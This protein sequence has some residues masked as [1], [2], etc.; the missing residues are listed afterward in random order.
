MKRQNYGVY[1]LNLRPQSFRFVNPD[2][3]G[4]T[5]N[6]RGQSL[7]EILIAV[8][9]TSVLLPA[10]V[11]G[12]VAST[13]GKSQ[14][15]QRVEAVALLKEAQ[16]AVRSVRERGWNTFPPNGAYHPTVE[17]FAWEFASNSETINGF[18]RTL[19]VSNVFRDANGVVVLSGG[20]L[21]PSTKRISIAITWGTPYQSQVASEMFVTRYLGNTKYSQT[22]EA[23][24]LTGTTTNTT[25]TNNAGGEVVLGARGGG[26]WCNPNLS[27]TALDLPKS[28]VANAIWAV[29][30]H[31]SAGTGEN[32][33]GVSYA[34]V[35]VT[36]TDPPAASI[37]GTFNGYKT[38]DIWTD[39]NYTYIATDNNGKEIVILDIS[40]NPPSEVGYFN[41]PGNG[42]GTAVYVS[43]NVGYAATGFDLYVF[44]VTSKVG[45]RPTLGDSMLLGGRATSI[46]VKG[47]YA[48]ISISSSPIELQIVDISN[49]ND[50]DYIG[51]GNVNG[52]DGKRVFVNDSQ[53]RAYLA[54]NTSSTLRELFILDVSTKTGSR[55]TIGSYETNGMNPKSVSVVPGNKAILVGTGGEEYQVVDITTETNPTRCGGL[56]IDTGVNGISSVLEGDGDAY[57][58]IITQDATFELKIIEGGPGGQFAT[59]GT[60]ESSIFAVGSKVAFNR[61]ITNATVPTDTTLTFQI[62]AADP[63]DGNCANATYTYVGPDGT[64]GSQFP[65]SGGAIPTNTDGS[66]FENPGRCIRYKASLSTTN[67]NVTPEILDVNVNYSL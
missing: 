16:E 1:P 55:P 36:D 26:D 8:A 48:Y 25:I 65:S 43:G 37:Q 45:S 39:G 13:G 35:S 12:L 61:F 42:N 23:D 60:F 58:Y 27:I 52:S 6:L 9:L 59:S 64:V 47:N 29:E 5:S 54:T 67:F 11:T 7:V 46:A 21:D 56:Q 15:T 49:P 66:G 3:I 30:G 53:T 18:T 57:S 41:A 32:A 63:A 34:R 31:I 10:L 4:I 62:A 22:T 24:F 50:L 17:N 14:E 20:T 19:T 33:S 44:D 38:N 2:S 28:G 51:W 40:Q